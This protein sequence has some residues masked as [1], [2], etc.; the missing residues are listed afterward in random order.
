MHV[1]VTHMSV[2]VVL[3][4]MLLIFAPFDIL[5]VLFTFLRLLHSRSGRSSRRFE[6]QAAGDFCSDSLCAA[7]FERALGSRTPSRS[8]VEFQ[9]PVNLAYLH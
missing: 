1:F 5:F 8:L 6:D 2:R 4:N 9:Q 7:H 3:Q